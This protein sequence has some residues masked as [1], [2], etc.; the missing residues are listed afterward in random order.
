VL[1]KNTGL[2]SEEAID[3]FYEPNMS[4]QGP[5]TQTQVILNIIFLPKTD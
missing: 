4:G 1:A 2:A 3:N 5:G